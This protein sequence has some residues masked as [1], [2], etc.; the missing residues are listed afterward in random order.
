MV[1]P[2]QDPEDLVVADL[3]VDGCLGGGWSRLVGLTGT[4][5]TG[6]GLTGTELLGTDLL[7]TGLIG[8][9]LL[10]SQM[11][12]TA[13]WIICRCHVPP[14]RLPRAES[15]ASRADAWP[16]RPP[17]RPLSGMSVP[18]AA[19]HSVVDLPLL[20]PRKIGRAS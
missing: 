13:A 10:G 18:A 19:G 4:G 5:L 20:F 11:L 16:R 14:P 1:M 15:A 7:G 8:T 12:G 3:I 2:G 6:T 17:R 9:D